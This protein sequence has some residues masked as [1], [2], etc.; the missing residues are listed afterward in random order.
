[1]TINIFKNKY[2]SYSI[3]YFTS[4]IACTILAL[5]TG[6]ASGGFSLTRKYAGFVNSQNIILR[7]ILYILT[8]VVFV[9][10]MLI[11]LVVFNTL[12]FWDGKVSQGT[13]NFKDKNNLYVVNHEFLPTTHLRQSTIVIKSDSNKIIQ[14]I[15]LTE[16]KSKEIEMRVDGVLRARVK[17]ISSLAIAYTFDKSGKILSEKTFHLNDLGAAGYIV[18]Q[19]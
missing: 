6:C 1:M 16:T 9:V 15:I 3:Y 14:E 7:I 19:K 5:S 13:Y 17:D 18:S 8:S 11:D 4:A 2:I 10:T 12:D